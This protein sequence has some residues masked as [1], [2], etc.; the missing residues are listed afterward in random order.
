ME[1]KKYLTTEEAAAALGLALGTLINWRSQGKGPKFLKPSPGV[2]RYHID[3][4]DEWMTA[5][6]KPLTAEEEEALG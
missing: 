3:A 2:V 5:N 1:D 6:E 4:I